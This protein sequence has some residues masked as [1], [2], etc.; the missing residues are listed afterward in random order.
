MTRNTFVGLF[1]ILILLMTVNAS[2]AQSD[3]EPERMRD[4]PLSPFILL[5]TRETL[6]IIVPGDPNREEPETL[7]NLVFEVI[8]RDGV[9]QRYEFTSF[10]PGAYLDSG[11]RTP[12]CFHLELVDNNDRLPQECI[13]IIDQYPNRLIKQRITLSDIFWYDPVTQMFRTIN[14]PVNDSL[15]EFC[16]AGV[17]RCPIG[18]ESLPTSAMAS[19]SSTDEM[20]NA[21]QETA[22]MCRVR[23]N[24]SNLVRVRVGPGTNRDVRIFLPADTDFPVVGQNV[25]RQGNSWWKLDVTDYFPT[26]DEAWVFPA[27]VQSSG[28]CSNLPI[29]PVS[30]II[31]NP[32]TATSP[33]IGASND[34][35]DDDDDGSSNSGRGSNNSGRGSNNDSSN[36]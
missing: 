5:P 7:R 15:V 4:Y 20:A 12:F 14:I 26:I 2:F 27:D 8:G 30:A 3:N 9:I 32:S 22:M 21:A 13:D 19:A 17:P 24:G 25:D 28:D 35:V 31:I 34:N 6:T 10:F 16:P 29:A 36:D 11:L 23:T 33:P 18:F 1:V